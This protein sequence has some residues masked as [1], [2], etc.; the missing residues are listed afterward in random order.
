MSLGNRI[1]ERRIQ[2][3]LTQGDVGKLLGMGR[4]NV[5]HIE[6]GRTNPTADVLDKIA[7]ILDTTADY[8]LGRTDDPGTVILNNKQE[9]TEYVYP[10]WATSK[11]KRD[12]R[13]Y[14]AEPKGLYFDGIE[15]TE[16]ERDKMLGVLE[17]IFWEA[18]K[19]NKEDYKKSR[20]QKNKSTE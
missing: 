2:K 11:D 3:G 14:I 13:A 20:E 4:S 9:Q 17:A 18:K 8:L 6:N 10:D 5:G 19:R 15:F 1:K 16:E 7:D 12:L